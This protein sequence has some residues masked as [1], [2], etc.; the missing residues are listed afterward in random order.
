MKKVKRDEPEQDFRG[1]PGC[2]Q[3]YREIWVI[4]LVEMYNV[5]IAATLDNAMR[6]FLTSP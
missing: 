1:Q 6:E 3:P 2:F 5:V 4:V